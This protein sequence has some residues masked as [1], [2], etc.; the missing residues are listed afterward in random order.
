MDTP[1]RELDL[2]HP[3][4]GGPL[5]CPTAFTVRSRGKSLLTLNPVELPGSAY[6]CSSGK[7]SPGQ[8]HP[9]HSTSAA[10]QTTSHSHLSSAASPQSPAG[11]WGG[12]CS[13]LAHPQKRFRQPL[14]AAS[15]C[16]SPAGARGAQPIHAP[17]SLA[18]SAAQ[19]APFSTFLTPNFLFSLPSLTARGYFAPDP[20]QLLKLGYCSTSLLVWLRV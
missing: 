20:G 3:A 10:H 8:G 16:H 19:T 7:C 1:C 17:P 11:A 13:L 6:F 9:C 14:Q 12:G 2:S 18:Q 15:P 5:Q 4:A